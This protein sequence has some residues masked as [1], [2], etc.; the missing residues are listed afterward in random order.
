MVPCEIALRNLA[1]VWYLHLWYQFL[2]S[3]E[4]QFLE[5]GHG[6]GGDGSD[7]DGL[8]E[9]Q[10]GRRK[11]FELALVRNFHLPCFMRL[12]YQL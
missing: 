7:D 2:Q 12:H 5:F 6:G 1:E 4:A 8:P 10:Y 9:I 11:G 3:V